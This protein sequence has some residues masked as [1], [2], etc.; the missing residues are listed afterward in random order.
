MLH[1]TTLLLALALLL[2]IVAPAQSDPAL[3]QIRK[4][5][6]ASLGSSADATRFRSLLQDALRATDFEVVNAYADGTLTG[7]FSSEAHGDYASARA[8]LQLKSRDGKQLLWSGDYSSQ[9]KGSIPE[10][11]IQTLANTC[12]KCLHRD[13]EKSGQ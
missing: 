3:H 5:R 2:P 11:V 13:W 6:I 7:A 4:I 1:R 12:A 8:T 9:H 10:D